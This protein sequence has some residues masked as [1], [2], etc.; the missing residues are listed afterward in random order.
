[1]ARARAVAPV[2]ATRASPCP[3]ARSSDASASAA[4][5]SSSTISMRGISARAPPMPCAVDCVDGCATTTIRST[6]AHGTR[7][8]VASFEALDLPLGLLARDAIRLFNLP[9]KTRAP[10]RN[11]VEV[12]AAEPPPVCVYLASE[13]LPAGF[14]KIPLLLGLPTPAGT[15]PPRRASVSLSSR[16]WRFA[17]AATATLASSPFG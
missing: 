14:H 4:P 6:K 11:Y 3:A 13:L 15:A 17:Y 9:R 16:R 1:M 5:T 2:Y 10:A 8:L 7:M 12:N